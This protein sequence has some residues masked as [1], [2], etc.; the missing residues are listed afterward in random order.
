MFRL[1]FRDRVL[2]FDPDAAL[3]YADIAAKRRT[4]GRAI[5]QSD[6]MIA[7]ISRSHDMVLATRNTKDFEG[8]GLRLINPFEAT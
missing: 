8:L 4:Q 7:A 2:S 5:S 6:A 3:H 1:D